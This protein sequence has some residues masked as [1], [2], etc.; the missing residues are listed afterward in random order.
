[1]CTPLL[2]R[3]EDPHPED[4]ELNAF[5]AGMRK[6]VPAEGEYP[7]GFAWYTYT[8][9]GPTTPYTMYFLAANPNIVHKIRLKELQGSVTRAL[10]TNA[11]EEKIRQ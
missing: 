10:I 1:M 9:S 5:L 2:E 6:I 8:P 7:R 4:T 11:P 3:P